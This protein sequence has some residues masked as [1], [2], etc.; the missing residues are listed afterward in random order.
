MTETLSADLAKALASAKPAP[1]PADKPAEKP[2]PKP[3]EMKPADAPPGA[4]P[5][6]GAKTFLGWVASGVSRKH[7]TI[8]AAALC[9][10]AAGIMAV[11]LIFPPDDF[12]PDTVTT[13][14]VAP[15]AAWP[16]HKP[17]VPPGAP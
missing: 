5:A 9:S 14:A 10:L 7:L 12:K 4:V 11:K 1:K 15:E 8:T 16:E 6:P 17:I 13:Q 3:P 2:I